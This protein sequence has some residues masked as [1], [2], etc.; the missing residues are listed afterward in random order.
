[1]GK[2][3]SNKPSAPNGSGD[4]SAPGADAPACNQISVAINVA[5]PRAVAVYHA[6]AANLEV[7]IVFFDDHSKQPVPF[8][9][10]VTLTGKAKVDRIK[11]FEL[12]SGEVA[13]PMTRQNPNVERLVLHVQ[14]Q[15]PSDALDDVELEVKIEKTGAMALGAVT[16]ATAKLTV[17]DIRA[18]DGIA[19]A[20]TV[21]PVKNDITAAA[22]THR[23]KLKAVPNLGGTWQWSSTSANL[24]LNDASKQTVQVQA[25]DV[26]SA[27]PRAEIL[28]LTATPAGRQPIKL[29]HNIGVLSVVFS[30]DPA[31]N[32]GYDKYEVIAGLDQNGAATSE[33]PTTKYDFVSIERSKDG[34]VQFEI[35]G[36]TEKD[37][38]F[39]SDNEAVVKPKTE[40][41]SATTGTH[42]LTAGAK[43]KDETVVNAR[44]VS[45]TGP[46]VA[47]LGVVVLKKL[48][49]EAEFFRVKDSGSASAAL[50][51]AVTG[52]ALE[53]GIK[54]YFKQGIATMA[55]TGGAAETDVAYDS[56]AT[57]T[58]NDA[59]DL[60]PGT[61][62]A[63][64]QI[65]KAQCPS[66]KQRVVQVHELRW[67]FY[68]A[69][70]AAA[71]TKRIRIKNYGAT[72]LG[73]IGN[74]T[75]TIADTAG[76]SEQVTVTARDRNTGWLDLQ[77][78]LGSDYKVADKAALIWPL[79]G[80]G[81]EPVLVSDKSS[82]ANL[83]NYVAH[84][85]SHAYKI[86]RLLD[87]CELNNLMHGGS[88]TGQL[89]RHRPLKLYY[90]TAN[91]EE[92]WKT[93]HG[94]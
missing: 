46:I 87:V 18:E 72:N 77:A 1:M 68:F 94:R 79:G 88:A 31:H 83:C 6:G 25:T 39:T 42:T 84:E 93:M 81:G 19:E 27:T 59:L 50:T 92:Q 17:V 52:V 23:V 91:T 21:V 78:N 64:E 73:Y 9:G 54:D 10:K 20:P 5:E 66:T 26:A 57:S 11:V 12:V 44:A 40:Q 51:L 75:Y 38:F 69:A 80:L 62:S 65:I 13:L 85:L 32:G 33:T 4:A 90:D 22:N 63:E 7:S 55:I 58:K 82:A 28:A 14:G 74:N 8:D 47:K 34:T 30:S 48:E 56:G 35:A 67:S 49:Y 37:V 41:A 71:G 60:E 61:T 76:H 36:G 16:Q 2:A 24:V 3:G 70:D 43:D 53:S 45:K 86:A 29:E 89:L 15:K